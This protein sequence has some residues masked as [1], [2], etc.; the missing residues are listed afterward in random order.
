[1]RATLVQL[2]VVGWIGFRLSRFSFRDWNY[3]LHL[4][5]HDAHPCHQASDRVQ[6]SLDPRTIIDRFVGR[7]YLL[8]CR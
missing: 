4:L 5:A 8:L 1:M 3:R 2:Q 7:D 6:T